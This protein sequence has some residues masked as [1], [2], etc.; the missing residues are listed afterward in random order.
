MKMMKII[1]IEPSMGG[2]PPVCEICDNRIESSDE[3]YYHGY[4]Y[5]EGVYTCCLRC[6]KELV[7]DE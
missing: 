2:F 5:G 1:Y 3:C 4:Y 6:A 7:G